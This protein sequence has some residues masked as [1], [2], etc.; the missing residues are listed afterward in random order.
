MTAPRSNPRGSVCI[1]DTQS[2]AGWGSVDCTWWTNRPPRLVAGPVEVRPLDHAPRPP[3][4]FPPPAPLASRLVRADRGIDIQCYT[5]PV[6]RCLFCST[7]LDDSRLLL[8]HSGG[9][10][11]RL[12]PSPTLTPPY[13]LRC[14]PPPVYPLVSLIPV[15]MWS[16]RGRPA[17]RRPR[18]EGG[19]NSAAVPSALVCLP[20]RPTPTT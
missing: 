1:M 12:V 2:S 8:S 18:V 9:N 3:R 10:L 16:I 6:P 5:A 11:R 4:P 19:A 15:Y 13:F 14:V 20:V 17:L 7:A